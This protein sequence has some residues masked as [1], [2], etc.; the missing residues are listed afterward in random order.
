MAFG[1][2]QYSDCCSSPS[3]CSRSWRRCSS[4]TGAV[5]CSASRSPPRSRSSPA[6]SPGALILWGFTILKYGTKREL[7]MRKERKQLSEL[8]ELGQVEAER[9][10]R[11]D[12]DSQPDAPCPTR[13]PGRQASPRLGREPRAVAPPGQAPL[14]DDTT[15]RSHPAAVQ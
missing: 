14:L 11:E 5:T 2:G 3:A 8:S 15:R 6:S 12:S 1:Q 10:D 13:R 9:D 4:A 7:R